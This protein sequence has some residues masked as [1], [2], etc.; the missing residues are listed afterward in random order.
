MPMPA[1]LLRVGVNRAAAGGASSRPGRTRLCFEPL[2][3]RRLLAGLTLVTHGFQAFGD[4]PDWL[5]SWQDAI[6][7]RVDPSG[8]DASR[9]E[10]FIGE[11]SSSISKYDPATPALTETASG[12]VIVTLDWAER[13]NDFFLF[14]DGSDSTADLIAAEVVPYL[15][16][17]FP[18]LGII[19]PLAGLPIHLIGHSRGA[20]VV[21]ELAR[22]LGEAGLWVEHLSLLDPHPLV[23]GQDDFV[24]GDEEDPPIEL[25]ENVYFTDNIWRADGDSLDFNGEF[26]EGA[27]NLELDDSI[28]DNG[29]YSLGHSDTH[30]FY[31]GT[32]DLALDAQEDG[33]SVPNNWYA[34][35]GVD[36]A[37]FGFYFSR[38]GGGFET[39]SADYLATGF[40]GNAAREPL[41]RSGSQWPNVMLD[42]AVGPIYA[43]ETFDLTLRYQDVDTGATISAWL[44]TDRNPFNGDTGVLVHTESLAAT[45]NSIVSESTSWTLP[46][47]ADGVYY[48]KTLIEDGSQ[49]RFAYAPQRLSIVPDQDQPPS[50]PGLPNSNADS[51]LIPALPM[52]PALGPSESDLRANAWWAGLQDLDDEAT[53]VKVLDE[54]QVRFE[55]TLSTASIQNFSRTRLG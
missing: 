53:P 44:D 5:D 23:A 4:R 39:I 22:E 49:Q 30:L 9:Y 37:E 33:T 47:G 48:L 27:L 8:T 25:Y 19:A 14:G 18:G 26:V 54:L 43:G 42:V 45:G 28:I 41:T 50:Q 52:L 16:T 36:R 24:S 31:Y 10:V 13:S 3:D 21:T 51:M 55:R 2:E 7:E 1:R 35:H 15:T 34:A 38:I 17:A 6:A 29:G 12:E 20:S 32:I 11:D 46:D 40:G